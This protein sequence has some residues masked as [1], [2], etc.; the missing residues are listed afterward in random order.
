MNNPY[1]TLGVSTTASQE[2][3]KRSYKKLARKYHPDV[4]KARGAE[5]EFKDVNAAYDA[6]G[7]PEKRKLYDE[8]GEVA[9]KPG[10][11]AQKAKAWQQASSGFGRSP[12]GGGPRSRAGGGGFSFDFGGDMDM[13]DF[14]S[15]LF[16]THTHSPSPRSE[17]GASQSIEMTID[18][19]TTFLGG[20]RRISMQRPNGSVDRIVV[21]IPAGAKDG[22]KLRIQGQ[23]L[24][25][26]G[27]GP[28]G[29][30]FITLNVPEHPILKRQGHDLEMNV[31]LTVLESL[32]GARITV[33]TPTG[34]VRVTI[35]AGVE[36]GT[37][38]RLKGRGVQR[39]GRA[40]DLYLV[41]QTQVPN[42]KEPWV[43]EAAKAMESAYAGDIRSGLKL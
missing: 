20:E 15:D 3:I 41:L 34:D 30:L 28:C 42:T 9:L 12:R 43:V 18:A 29:D 26:R 4:N 36:V 19:M 24:P 38:M 6:V 25:P 21:K 2:D 22:V 32:E 10:F 8:F 40:G 33:P 1:A 14:L 35:P 31:P 37:R 11:D 16:S 13:D 27:G 5:Q 7:D 17:R 39:K 23:G